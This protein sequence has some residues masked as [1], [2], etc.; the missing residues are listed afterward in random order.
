MLRTK[1]I[2]VTTQEDNPVLINL[3]LDVTVDNDTTEI[4]GHGSIAKSTGTL[5]MTPNLTSP[6]ASK[7]TQTHQ[8]EAHGIQRPKQI[9]TD[10]KPIYSH[11]LK[12]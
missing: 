12:G 6:A 4:Y 5:N 10:A 1:D 9:S 11:R 3:V 2:A 8:P 7:P